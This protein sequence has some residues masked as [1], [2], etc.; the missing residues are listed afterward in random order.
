MEEESQDQYED[1]VDMEQLIQQIGM[2]MEMELRPEGE[3]DYESVEEVEYRGDFKPELAQLMTDLRM[4]Q[5]D[6]LGQSEGDP[7]SQEQ[8]QE[9]LENSAE[10]DL[11]SVQ[12]EIQDSSGMFA[13]NIMKE[14]GSLS[15]I[16][17]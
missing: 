12:G 1:A 5:Q 9:L 16:H 14:M 11:Q 17:I 15:L 7:L 10:L 6:E 2:G 8:L 3:E 4:Q 13:D